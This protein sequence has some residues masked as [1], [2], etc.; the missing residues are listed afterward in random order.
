[1]FPLKSKLRTKARENI[2]LARKSLESVKRNAYETL[3]RFHSDV[4][5]VK[6]RE[7]LQGKE[8]R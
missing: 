2:S 3:W 6:K 1:M 4:P 7:R 5:E 8:V